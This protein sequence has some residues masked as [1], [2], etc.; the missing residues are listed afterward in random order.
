MLSGIEDRSII[1]IK[2]NGVGFGDVNPSL[3]FKR[4]YRTDFSRSRVKGGSGLGLPIVHAIVE[5]ND[6]NITAF[7]APEGG[8]VFLIAFPSVVDN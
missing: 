7:N 3:L 8:A 1:A 6:G 4:F 2:D 5:S